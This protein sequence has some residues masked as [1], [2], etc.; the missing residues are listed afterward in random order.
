MNQDVQP[1]RATPLQS[2]WS[3]ALSATTVECE[4]FILFNAFNKYITMHEQGSGTLKTSFKYIDSC[5]EY[6]ITKA[7]MANSIA[8]VKN[9][10]YSITKG[11]Y[12]KLNSNSS[13]SPVQ[14]YKGRM[15]QIQKA[16]V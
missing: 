4:R 2:A 14:Y 12:G 15:W 6:C 11:R 16:K 8:T 10:Q 1:D 3:M 13:K 5:V 7:G 9:H